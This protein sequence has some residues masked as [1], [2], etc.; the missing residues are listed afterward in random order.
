MV[1]LEEHV[2]VTQVLIGC[3]EH[4]L[5]PSELVLALKE[6]LVLAVLEADHEG[7]LE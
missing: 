5:G 2:D 4:D 7:A 1:L 3:L 6:L